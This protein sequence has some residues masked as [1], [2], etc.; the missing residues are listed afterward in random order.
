M[1]DTLEG[2]TR[3]QKYLQPLNLRQAGMGEEA[4]PRMEGLER[5][6]KT[7]PSDLCLAHGKEYVTKLLVMQ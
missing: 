4:Q 1:R 2:K 5:N 7:L 6:G 3:G